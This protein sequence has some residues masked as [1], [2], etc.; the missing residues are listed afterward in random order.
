M[1]KGHIAAKVG[2]AGVQ[3]ARDVLSYI[4]EGYLP[5]TMLSFI[6]YSAGTTAPNK[7]FSHATS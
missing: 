1:A 3:G 5:E 7:K 4:D 2:E 6:K